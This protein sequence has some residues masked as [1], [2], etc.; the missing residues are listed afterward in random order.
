[1]HARVGDRFVI[2]LGWNTKLVGI[3]NWEMQYQKGLI[4]VSSDQDYTKA[5]RPPTMRGANATMIWLMEAT[6][7]G[8]YTL[9]ATALGK[10]P[11]APPRYEDFT[12]T[13]VV[14]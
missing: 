8:R 1:M 7:R 6:K 2:A 3:D 12:M 13:V 14:S 10:Q 5:P 9:E 11:F 4:V